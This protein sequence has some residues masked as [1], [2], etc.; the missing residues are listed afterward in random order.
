MAEQNI[1][2][3]QAA[4]RPERRDQNG[5]QE[6][7]QRDHHPII[8]DSISSE[9]WI[10]FSAQ[11]IDGRQRHRLPYEP[12]GQRMDNAAMESFFSSLKTERTSSS[13]TFLIATSF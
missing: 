13:S 3:E 1:L 4:A 11:T 8:A 12:I 2:G 5:Q 6:R 9:S 7:E 10:E